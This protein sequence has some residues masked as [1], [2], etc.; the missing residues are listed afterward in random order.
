MYGHPGRPL[1]AACEIVRYPGYVSGKGGIDAAD[2]DED[3]GVYDAGDAAV[4]GC[5]DADY[6]ADPNSAH[7][8][9]D[10]GGA[11]AGAVGEPGDG[12]GEDGCRDVDGY[13]QELGGGGCIA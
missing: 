5:A 1:V 6:E 12:D 4:S 8:G 10:V 13:G 7:A 9:E 2:G 11:L 3:A